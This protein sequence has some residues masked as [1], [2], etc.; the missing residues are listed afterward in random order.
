MLTAAKAFLANRV[1]AATGSLFGA[2][3][4]TGAVR[5]PRSLSLEVHQK[6]L[7]EINGNH[8]EPVVNSIAIIGGIFKPEMSTGQDLTLLSICVGRI[9]QLD[10]GPSPLVVRDLFVQAAKE[11]VQQWRAV[12]DFVVD[13]VRVRVTIPDVRTRKG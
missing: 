7:K 2:D 10:G 5:T 11:R 12:I 1:E 3:L 13:R 4:G 8:A 6:S 9:D